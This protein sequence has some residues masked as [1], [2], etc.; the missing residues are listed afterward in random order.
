MRYLSIVWKDEDS[1]ILKDTTVKG[2]SVG[3]NEIT[4]NELWKQT[5]KSTYRRI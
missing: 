5:P 4:L 2:V 1:P 3:E